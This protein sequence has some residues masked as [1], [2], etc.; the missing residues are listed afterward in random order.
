MPAERRTA[1]ADP[2][3]LSNAAIASEA[4]WVD[5]AAR[6]IDEGQW[7]LARDTAQTGSKQ[8]PQNTKLQQ[9]AARALIQIG[10]IEAAREILEKLCPLVKSDDPKFLRLCGDIGELTRRLMAD[11][12]GQ[13]PSAE[14]RQALAQ[15]L[16]EFGRTRELLP[17]AVA[18]D[19]ET[20]GLLARVYKGS[21]QESGKPEDASK[22]RDTYLRAFSATSGL[23]SGINAATMSWIVG[24]IALKEGNKE[25]ARSQMEF[26]RSLAHQVLDNSALLDP[27]ATPEEQYWHHATRGEAFLLLRNTSDAITS[28]E[29]AASTAGANVAQTVSSLRQLQLLAANG[30]DVPAK[31]REIIAPPTIVIFSGHMI[32]QP[33]RTPPRFPEELVPGVRL[34]IDRCLDE[35]KARIGYCSAACG[36]DILF[37]EAMQDRDAEV[38]IVLPFAIDDFLSTSVAHAGEGWVRRCKRA[39]KVAGDSVRYVT[40]EGYLGTAD[41]FAYAAK[42]FHGYAYLRAE[43][44][45]TKPYLVTVFDSTSQRLRGGTA[46]I[47]ESW[48]DKNRLRTIDLAKMAAGISNA[49]APQPAAPLDPRASDSAAATAPPG[50]ERVI[51]TMLFADVKG[52]SRLQEDHVPFYMLQFLNVVSKHL[53]QHAAKPIVVN[54]WGDAI[55]AVM[56]DAM[57]MLTYA[58]ALQ[59]VV[60]DTDWRSLGLPADFNVRIGLHAGPVFEGTDAITKQKNFFGTHVN[61]AARIEPITVPGQIYASEQFVALLTTEQMA[62]KT[63]PLDDWPFK[64]E[65]LGRVA[66]AKSAGPLPVYHI[67]KKKT[68]G[69]KS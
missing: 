26:S 32:D 28:Y 5:F 47:R 34:E 52:F 37:I 13:P 58:Q 67:R 68:A 6:Y 31:L 63:R 46:D 11:R 59:D 53:E 25:L 45:G 14:S 33:G 39:L 23:W 41:L 66:L 61:R 60:R 8:F 7:F 65:Y 18:W 27:N 30:F 49:P 22:S 20:L 1:I 36:S 64:C 50:T 29:R 12:A 9:L 43:S 2:S 40:H 54:T 44:F 16:N 35:L 3:M 57:P 51:R 48:P 62:D 19:E 69:R 10:A 17:N 21:W 38:N 15:L 55:F 42:I 4:D 24:Q 56:E